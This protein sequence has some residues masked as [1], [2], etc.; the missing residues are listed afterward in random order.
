MIIVYDCASINLP[1]SCNSNFQLDTP[2]AGLASRA[3]T[4]ASNGGS[5]LFFIAVGDLARRLV[6]PS[7]ADFTTV[8]LNPDSG[9]SASTAAKV[10][11]YLLASG[12][13]LAARC[14]QQVAA[15]GDHSCNAQD[16]QRKANL[17]DE[18]QGWSD[19]LR[20]PVAQ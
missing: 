3:S 11:R 15:T 10:M 12:A 7:S 9:K 2:E 20:D 18:L 4:A 19:R 14:L 17:G 13:F 8:S 5:R 6:A 16:K 1:V